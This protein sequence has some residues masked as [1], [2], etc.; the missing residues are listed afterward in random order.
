MLAATGSE[1]RSSYALAKT[2]ANYRDL[3]FIGARYRS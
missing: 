3:T 2:V 1:I